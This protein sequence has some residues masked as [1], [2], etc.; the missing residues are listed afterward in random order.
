MIAEYTAMIA[1]APAAL[2][3][4]LHW[5]RVRRVG[6][7]AF[8]PAAKPRGW[9][10]IVPFARPVSL[11]ALAWGLA[12]LYLLGATSVKSKPMPDGGWR[13]LVIALDVSPSMRLED[14]GP[15]RKQLRSKRASEVVMSLLERIALDQVRVSVV[16]FY[17]GA[18]PVV[19]D[20][21]DQAVVKNILDDLPID[22]A[23]DRGKTRLIDGVRESLELAKPWTRESTTLLVVSDGDTL[24]DTGLP[25]LPPSIGQV[26]VIGVGDAASGS[27]ID[28]HQSRQD[29][30]TLRQLATRLHGTYH[31]GN[32]KHLP[33]RQLYALSTI[34]ALRDDTGFGRR[35]AALAAVGSGAGLLAAIPVAL[36]LF[37]SG[38]QPATRSGKKPFVRTTATGVSKTE[39]VGTNN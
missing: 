2:A 10:M 39:P 31:D 16:A 13:H 33:S 14:S 15:G 25:P 34:M 28:G 1:L 24:P 12:T 37:G 23:F 36:A 17:T 4:W 3:E 6:R 22:I 20:T 32:E 29:A 26:L 38:W 19:V 7:L 35:Q 5:R 9:T 11:A 18:K 30:S 8:G 21:M 27:F